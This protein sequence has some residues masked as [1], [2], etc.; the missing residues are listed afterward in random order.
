[1]LR[2][3]DLRIEQETAVPVQLVDL[4]LESVV[5]GAGRCLECY[6]ALKDMFM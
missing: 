4:P 3:F 6:D 2:G 5:L 1:M